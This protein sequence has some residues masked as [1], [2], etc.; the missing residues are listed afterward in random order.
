MRRL[1][2]SRGMS[3]EREDFGQTADG[4]PVERFVLRSPGGK[5]STR[6]ITYGGHVTELRVPDRSGAVE[7]VVL[8]FDNLA[9]YLGDHPYF[10]SIVGRYA[11]RIANGRFT[12]DGREYTL[13]QNNGANTLHGGTTGFTRV[14]WKPAPTEAAGVPSL[15]LE[16]ISPDGQDGFP[17]TMH[18]TVVYTLD[19]R[20][21]RIDYTATTD[22][23][24]VVNLTNHSYFNLRGAGRG[25]VLGHVL[26]LSADA[27]TPVDAALIPTGE[28]APVKG[29]L[30][31]FTQPTEIG[32]RIA[33]V[34]G[35]GYDHNYVLSTAGDLSAPAARA[36]EPISGRT[37]DV[38]TT[39]PGVQ[40]YTGNFLDGTIHGRGGAYG[41]HAGFCLETQHYPDSPHHPSFPSTVL[42]PNQM[43]RSTTIYRFGAA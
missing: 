25:D 10:G 4:Q 12:L 41:R 32:K 30:F 8:G 37:M 23:P 36:L 38:Y 15:R 20:D 17:G 1:V 43:F 28:I 33:Q 18:A 5:L 31:D 13:P 14:V 26:T 6:I 29:T 9:G 2:C 42:R 3:I 7:N 11:N 21:L 22:K 35:G 24:T 40:L 27:Y 16:Y 34:P 39:E 19:D